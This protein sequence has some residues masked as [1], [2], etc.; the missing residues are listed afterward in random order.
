MK[1]YLFIL[2]SLFIASCSSNENFEN[3]NRDPNNPTQVSSEALFTS[4]TKTLFDQTES[5]SEIGR[6]H[7]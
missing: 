6:A 5:T 3:L 7:V 4:A 2:S 1:K